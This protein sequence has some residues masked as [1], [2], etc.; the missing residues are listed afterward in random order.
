[1]ASSSSQLWA[2]TLHLSVVNPRSTRSSNCRSMS[3]TGPIHT[4]PLM[5]IPSSPREK[6]DSEITPRPPPFKSQAAI[7]TAKRTAGQDAGTA[8]ASKHP[9]DATRS[10]AAT[11]FSGVSGESPTIRLHSPTPIRPW[12]S[13]ATRNHD[14]FSVNVSLEVI[15]GVLNF[16]GWFTIAIRS[17]R[18]TG[19]GGQIDEASLGFMHRGFGP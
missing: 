5:S 15:A 19:A 9:L 2:P 4:K 17:P 11:A 1:M 12:A 3:S 10:R 7:S 8:M 18:I 13:S 16:K 6:G 14:G